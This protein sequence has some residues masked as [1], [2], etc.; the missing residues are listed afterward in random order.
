[1]I[2]ERVFDCIYN[3][4]IVWI[5]TC[6]VLL[7]SACAEGPAAKDSGDSWGDV[8]ERGHGTLKALYV[9]AEGF[10]YRDDEGRLTGVTVELIRDMAVFVKDMFN[11]SLEIE[12]VGEDDWS[13]FYNRIVSGGD[14]LI[15][16]GNVTITTER[17]DELIFSP[18]YMNNIASLITHRDVAELESFEEIST[19]FSGMTALAFKGTLHEERLRRVVQEYYPSAN[20]DFASA[21]DEILRR[22]GEGTTYFAYID[23]Y[24]YLRASNREELR[25]HSTG[26][27]PGEQFG[28]IMPLN[29]SWYEVVEL[30]FN[31]NGGL[32]DSERYRE[33]MEEHL[34]KEVAALLI[35]YR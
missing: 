13:V 33:I 2:R 5:T 10:A 18:P 29:T 8:M 16:F 21:N 34:G 25:R 32:T 17:R 35:D 12:F 7:L 11:V 26:D 24:N 9:P 1:M 4:L 31:H 20:I 6:L 19:Q 3:R 15:G 28:Y 22:V 14:G 23:L 30:Y 27:D